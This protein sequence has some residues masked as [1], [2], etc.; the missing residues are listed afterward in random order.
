M[1]QVQRVQSGTF[2][3]STKFFT[4]P[5]KC[6]G[7]Y[8]GTLR[9]MSALM[10]YMGAHVIHENVQWLC[11]TWVFLQCIST[12]MQYMDT[13]ALRGHICI[14]WGNTWTRM[15]HVDT[16]VLHGRPCITGLMY[17]SACA[18]KHCVTINAVQVL[19]AI[20]ASFSFDTHAFL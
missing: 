13:H 10:Q 3:N 20:R 9:C 17:R 16:Y 6:V 2:R 19:A 12:F 8:I 15:H 5:T 1:G 14:T 11:N 18:R 7:I 4:W